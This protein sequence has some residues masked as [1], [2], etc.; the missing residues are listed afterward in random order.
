LS[1]RQTCSTSPCK[2][3]PFK[4]ALFCLLTNVC[5]FLEVQPG[6]K[7]WVEGKP[8]TADGMSKAFA[9]LCSA[10]NLPATGLYPLRHGAAND[11]NFCFCYIFKTVLMWLVVSR[12]HGQRT[13]ENNAQ[14]YHRRGLG[15]LHFGDGKCGRCWRPFTRTS[16]RYPC[17]CP[18]K[19]SISQA[20]LSSLIQDHSA[21]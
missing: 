15:P 14:S 3:F 20:F 10:V 8:M 21:L 5:S 4:S 6:G 16:R 9:V 2:Y 19:S 11:V 7:G 18:G 17:K 12:S 1:S 13:S